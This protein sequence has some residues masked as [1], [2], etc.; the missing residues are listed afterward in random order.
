MRTHVI[1]IQ[2][3]TDFCICVCVCVRVENM[4]IVI[5]V[6]LSS[7]QCVYMRVFV[8]MYVCNICTH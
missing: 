4:V 5:V 3:C 2:L 8:H 7:A 1:I 6:G